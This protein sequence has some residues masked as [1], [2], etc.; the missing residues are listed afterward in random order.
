MDRTMTCQKI[1]C[2]PPRCA[3]AIGCATKKGRSEIELKVKS[4]IPCLDFL[5]PPDEITTLVPHELRASESTNQQDPRMELM[6]ERLKSTLKRNVKCGGTVYRN[7]MKCLQ[8]SYC[9]RE[10]RL[11]NLLEKYKEDRVKDR[12]AMKIRL[13][14]MSRPKRIASPWDIKKNPFQVR[15]SALQYKPTERMM[16]LYKPRP[17]QITPKYKPCAIKYTFNE[18]EAMKK[19]WNDR[20]GKL[21]GFKGKKTPSMYLRKK[22]RKKT[23]KNKSKKGAKSKVSLLKVSSPKKVQTKEEK[24]LKE[25]SLRK[26]YD[27]LAQPRR[28]LKE[29]PPKKKPGRPLADILKRT[30]ELLATVKPPEPRINYDDFF[31]AKKV[32]EGYQ[33]SPRLLEL[34]QPKSLASEYI[35]DL[36]YVWKVKESALRYQA[37]D[38]IKKLAEPRVRPAPDLDI[39]PDAFKVKE[40]ALNYKATKRI[41]E[42]AKPRVYPES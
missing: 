42:L 3:C 26:M 40:A 25:Q 12:E 38:R 7:I 1:I 30:N 15:K 9:N 23:K 5:N 19:K 24:E 37:T 22:G 11:E 2:K 33:P 36:E 29:T 16:Q 39:D 28:K 27:R 35:L 21:R 34:A 32:P 31:R 13:I 10:E 17:D 14:A 41:K 6:K 4:F 18:A 8:T 20:L